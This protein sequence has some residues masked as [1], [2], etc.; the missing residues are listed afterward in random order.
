MTAAGLAAFAT[1]VVL[2]FAG[3]RLGSRIGA[4]DRP[5]DPKRHDR[6]T[7]YLGG[8]AV[9]G[10]L[11]AGLALKGWPLPWAA[12][13]ALAAA[14]LVG[15]ADDAIGVPPPWP[16]AIEVAI[17]VVLA[18]GGLAPAALP[19]ALGAITAVVVFASTVNAVNMVDGLDALA[20]GAAALSA[21]GLAVIAARAGHAGPE[22]IALVT[23]GAA[24]GILVHNLPPAHLL[25]GD[26]GAYLL[27]A[28]LSVAVLADGRTAP[29]LLGAGACLGVF[30]LDLVLAL[31]RRVL[32][33]TR[34]IEGDRSHM[35]DQLRGRGLSRGATVLVTWAVHVALIVAGVRAAGTS[36]GAALVTTGALWTLALAWLLVG[37]FVTARPAR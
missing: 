32:G 13:V 25:L 20:G 27:G 16:L 14:F 23:A 34:L 30:V 2:G 26:N 15:L 5:G 19:G 29:R 10:G 9:A 6:P 22:V 11:A 37:G 21:G 31:V 7:P 17:G 33:R 28:A 12:T 35:Y 36:T 8:V 18:A 4:A 1:S 3:R 24:V